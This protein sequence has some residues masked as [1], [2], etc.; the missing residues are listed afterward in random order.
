M[1]RFLLFLFGIF[2][3]R[4]A[5]AQAPFSKEFWLNESNIPV[6]V[7]DIV[8]GTKGNV[9][10][11]T[12]NGLYRFNGRSFTLITDSVNQPVTAVASISGQT[13][14]GYKNGKMG[15]VSGNRMKLFTISHYTPSSTIRSIHGN[16]SILFVTT[17]EEGL[18]VVVN[19]AGLQLTTHEGL[20]DNFIYDAA[21]TPHHI[22]I[23]TDRGINRISLKNGKPVTD[24]Y[25]TTQG[26]P[27]NIVRVITGIPGTKKYWLGTQESGL[28]LFDDEKR[29]VQN[30]KLAHQWAWGQINDILVT[31][32]D[33]AWVATET[34]YLLQVHL[35][36]DSIDVVPFGFS[37]QKINK[38]AQDRANNL[39]CATN[40][41]LIQ[42][43]ALYARKIVLPA[44][45]QLNNVTAVRFDRSN[46]L[47]FSQN[48]KLYRLSPT[49]NAT[50]QLMAKTEAA[51]SCLE[52]DANDHL[53]IGSF[54][55]GLYSYN[56][57]KVSKV[58]TIASLKEG[59]ILSIAAIRDH[60]WIAS[61]NGVEE[62]MQNPKTSSL[63]LLRHHNK[64]SG[65][66]SDYVYQLFPDSK[67]K[68][69]MATDG[70]GVCMYDGSNYHHWPNSSGFE[71][72]VVYTVSE[73][74][75]GNIWAGSLNHGVFELHNNHWQHYGK[76]D[77][78]QEKNIYALKGNATGEMIVVNEDGIDEWYPSCHQFRHYNRRSGMDIDSVLKVPNCIARDTEGR[79][80]VPFEKGFVILENQEQK[81]NINAAVHISSVSL[82]FK[83]LA[84]KRHHFNSGENHLSFRFNG[85][86][87]TNPERLQ[88]RYKL[89]NNDTNWVYTIDENVSFAQLSPGKYTFMVQAS[90][91]NN[92]DHAATDSYSFTIAKPV[93][94]QVWFVVFVLLAFITAAYS[95]IRLRERELRK[96]SQLQKERMSFEYEHLKSQVNPHFLF[97]SLNTLV[98][99]IEEDKQLASDYTVHLSDLYRNMLSYK[100]QNLIPLSEEYKI[101][102]SYMH[103][104]QSRFGNALQLI[105]DIPEHLFKT[106]QI[107]PLALQLLVEN[108]I[109]H[110]V[111]SVSKPLTIYITATEDEITVRNC[112]QPKMSKE[113]SAGIGIVNIEK[114]YALLTDR[115]TKFGVEERQYVVKL[116]LL[117]TEQLE[118]PL[119][120]H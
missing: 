4:E 43:T 20:S 46:N 17:E 54:G 97:N 101:L 36:Q 31:K 25:T 57:K 61:L 45:Y 50:P 86:N 23:A 35:Y 65:I 37:E 18:F 15:I 83:P 7:N 32:S 113:K 5:T 98:S 27:D 70:A 30:V 12:N 81:V 71:S 13:Y 16:G 58:V 80:F 92:F 107:V 82:F 60:L 48:N 59:H 75:K 21:I 22:I 94:Q 84:E 93:W 10:L 76:K 34:G 40:Q 66:G 62:T 120:K 56:N 99:L 112:I 74:A 39:W 118:K 52:F 28:V 44:P 79:V 117:K 19:G 38:L 85:I 103:I 119:K 6:Q 3:C 33:E 89:D 116:P 91:N 96:M 115:P 111:V 90:L 14:A 53:W 63:R 69:W 11:G 114:R 73:D 109:K 42:S 77:G 102:L 2:I 26:L 9:W 41:G 88:Y 104:Q 8:Y 64:Q 78:L 49:P 100:D 72:K 68:M 67:G 106:T 29:I 24:I 1:L 110:N 51:I 55:T 105:T 87:F 47:W 95:Y 108:A